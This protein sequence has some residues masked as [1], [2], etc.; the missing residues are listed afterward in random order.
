MSHGFTNNG[1]TCYMNSA[2]Q[3]LSH[4]PIFHPTNET[5]R[6][7]VNQYQKGSPVLR[8][9]IRILKQMWNGS[10]G[11][12]IQTLPFLREFIKHCR[13]TDVYFESFQQNDSA[14]FIRIFMDFIHH[15][16]KREVRFT[17]QGDPTNKV[18]RLKSEAVD[19]WESFF[20][21]EYSFIIPYFYSQTLTMVNCPKCEYITTNFEPVMVITL[22]MKEN[23]TSI[24]DCLN[25]YTE[26]HTTD[27]QSQW[28]CDECSQKVNPYKKT[29]FWK[30]SPVLIFQIKQYRKQGKLNHHIEFPETLNMKEYVV[31]QK[32]KNVSYTLS[33]ICIHS[34][35]LNGG[36]YYAMC[37]DY[38]KNTWNIHND[39]NVTPTKLT[40]VLQ[41]TPYCLFYTRI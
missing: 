5:F 26:K 14:D 23:Y 25:E 18:E 15:S 12:V 3:C 13:E 17:K 22:T 39:S 33:G 7:N 8:E 21:K 29:I 34:G 38:T 27:A 1:N 9:W 35:S 11:E 28:T 6:K 24:Y 32:N 41:Q 31:N 19:S 20:S 4:L 36:H 30:V 2:L 10:Q 16:V 40:N 37:K